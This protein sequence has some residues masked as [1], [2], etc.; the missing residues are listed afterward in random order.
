MQKRKKHNLHQYTAFAVA[1]GCKTAY[2]VYDLEEPLVAN[3]ATISGASE[4]RALLMAT[5]SAIRWCREHCPKEWLE[6]YFTD[7]RV[8]DEL[9]A[10][11]Y[12]KDVNSFE[13]ADRITNITND[14]CFIGN[15]VFDVVKPNETGAVG[16]YAKRIKGLLKTVGL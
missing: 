16:D 14:C 8:P 9:T 4:H 15:V 13:D 1:N 12:G 10:V 11:W 3:G 5:W 7:R 2:A 6:I